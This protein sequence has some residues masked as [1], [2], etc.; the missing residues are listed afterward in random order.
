VSSTFFIIFS[1]SRCGSTALFRALSYHRAITCLFEPD[2]SSAAW[3]EIEVLRMLERIRGEYSGIKHVWDP[4][5]FPFTS[6]HR[7]VVN[8]MNANREIV[9]RLNKAVLAMPHKK[10]VFL[11]RRNHLARVLSDLLGQQTGL[12]GPANPDGRPVRDLNEPQRYRDAL[13]AQRIRPLDIAIVEWYLKNAPAMEDSLR[14]TLTND[15]CLEL[16]YED[17]LGP[18][19]RV[20]QRLKI[21]RRVLTFLDRS[22]ESGCWD[23]DAVTELFDPGRKLNVPELLSRIPNLAEIQSRFSSG[24]G[25]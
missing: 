9:V 15:E 18:G 1:L 5:G 20:D 16:F 14:Q 24:S 22:Q 25:N 17:F 2:F 8:Q 6:D 12:W 11:R 7:S 19:I 4:S 10:V 23:D 3:V 21:Y 13:N